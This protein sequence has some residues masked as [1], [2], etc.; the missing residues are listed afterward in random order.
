MGAVSGLLGL[1]PGPLA[2]QFIKALTNTDDELS[3]KIVSFQFTL[4]NEVSTI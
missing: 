2:N 1:G 3:A 4:S